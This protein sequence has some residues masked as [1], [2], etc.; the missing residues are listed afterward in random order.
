MVRIVKPK[1]RRVFR[2]LFEQ[3]PFEVELSTLLNRP[4]HFGGAL[5]LR[6]AGERREG[7]P[8]VQSAGSVLRAVP[9]AVRPLVLD[10]PVVEFSDTAII[11]VSEAGEHPCRVPGPADL[12]VVDVE[13]RTESERVVE[14]QIR[15]LPDPRIG[16]IEPEVGKDQGSP[17]C[18][19]KRWEIEEVHPL[20]NGPGFAALP[21][22]LRP[23]LTQLVCRPADA[24]N[25]RPRDPNFGV[26]LSA[27]EQIH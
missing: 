9:T 13:W 17:I 4:S 2:P 26:V 21:E 24:T 7:L 6:D 27:V 22:S 11:A 16:R 20:C 10:E 5:P 8:G 18:R 19:K 25:P 15:E 12:F 1:P 14:H 3:L 23:L